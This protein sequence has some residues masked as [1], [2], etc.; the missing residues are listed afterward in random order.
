MSTQVSSATITII[1]I[2]QLSMRVSRSAELQVASG[3]LNPAPSLRS[4][5]P[6][7]R[8]VDKNDKASVEA[9]TC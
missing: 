3:P 6:P 1:S 9:G 2:L 5:E 7:D 4:F 8:K